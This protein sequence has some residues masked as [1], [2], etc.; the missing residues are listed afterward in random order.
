LVA[1][2]LRG[3]DG[4]VQAVKMTLPDGYAADVREHQSLGAGIKCSGEQRQVCG[5]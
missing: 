4:I 3:D 5:R 1:G 2:H